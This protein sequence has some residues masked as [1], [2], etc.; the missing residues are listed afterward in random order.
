MPELSRFYGIVIRMFFDDHNPPHFHARYGGDEA[1]VSISNLSVV[2]ADL[3]GERVI[4]F[5]PSLSTGIGSEEHSRRFLKWYLGF[6]F[7]IDTVLGS[8]GPQ[9]V[10]VSDPPDTPDIW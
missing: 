10:P 7:H 2:A 1:I 4:S 8:M 5:S 6:A 9:S 3:A